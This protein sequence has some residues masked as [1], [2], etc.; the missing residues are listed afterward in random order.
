ME[1]N[2]KRDY[3]FD[4]IKFFLIFLVVFGHCITNTIG[5]YSIDKA[6]YSFIYLFHMPCFVII[7]GYFS[8]NTE[9]SA[10]KVI[11]LFMLYIEFQLLQYLF[12]NYMMKDPTDLT[13]VKPYWSLWFLLALACWKLLLP[14]LLRIRYIFPASIVLG[15]LVGYDKNVESYLAL[16]RIITFLPFFLFGY[17]LKKE[18][19]KKFIT[20]KKS[21]IVLWVGAI[22][23]FSMICCFNSKIDYNWM[24]ACDPYKSLTVDWYA[25]IYRIV[26]YILGFV[27]SF[28]VFSIIPEE[29]TIFTKIGR[30]SLNIYL[31]HGFVIPALSILSLSNM[32]NYIRLAIYFV[33]TLIITVVFT[34]NI[35]SNI[36]KLLLQPKVNIILKKNDREVVGGR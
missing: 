31:L 5:Q 15:I 12:K 7:S 21:R 36:V 25:G 3:Y 23:I 35:V 6:I 29:K 13:F 32:P 11:H 34:R 22:C 33:T 20:T 30:N 8:K 2:M 27:L 18:H 24:Y 28:F 17:Y 19:I 16:S 26:L 1:S 4:N 14:Y 9:N 10:K